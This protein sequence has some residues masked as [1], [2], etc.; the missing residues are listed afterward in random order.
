M[1]AR[2]EVET[3]VAAGEKLKNDREKYKLMYHQYAKERQS[4]MDR[5]QVARS[6]EKCSQCPYF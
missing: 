5:L 2:A 6:S 4:A 3:H 1:E